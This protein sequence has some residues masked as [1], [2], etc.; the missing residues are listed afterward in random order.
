ME[1]RGP[2]HHL[3]RRDETPPKG[4]PFHLPVLLREKQLL[5]LRRAALPCT[6]VVL[7]SRG[8]RIAPAELLRKEPPSGLLVAMDRYTTPRWYC[9]LWDESMKVELLPRLLHA[10][11]E[12]E[13]EGVRLSL[14][15]HRGRAPRAVATSLALHPD[16]GEGA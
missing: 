11:L 14:W 8:I 13:N 7:R 5:E 4:P 10:Q 1:P 9:S 2:Q 12:R 15:W 6:V 16:C 3:M